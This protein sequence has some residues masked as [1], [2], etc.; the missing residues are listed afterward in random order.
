MI[1]ENHNFFIFTILCF[2][3]SRISLRRLRGNQSYTQ[4]FQCEIS[5]NQLFLTIFAL[6]LAAFDRCYTGHRG[7]TKALT[8]ELK[9]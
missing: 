8:C 2:V 5:L 4:Y 3:F 6:G 9:A 7:I 1:Y